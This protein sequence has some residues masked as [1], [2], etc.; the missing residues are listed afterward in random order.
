MEA[1]E[2]IKW[3]KNIKN[4]GYIENLL[5]HSEAIDMAIKSLE[6]EPILDKVS[7][8]YR[9]LLK[10]MPKDDWASIIPYLMHKDMG[11]PMSECQKAY[12]IAIDYLRSQGKVK[13]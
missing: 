13:G 11:I 7:D 6:Q 1:K 2:A 12:D 8:N 5:N 3:L 9:V 10:N 4:V